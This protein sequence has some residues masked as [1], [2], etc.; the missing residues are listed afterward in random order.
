[1]EMSRAI[2]KKLGAIEADAR[3]AGAATPHR[4]HRRPPEPPA[5]QRQPDPDRVADRRVPRPRMNLYQRHGGRVRMCTGADFNG[6][7][8]T[9]VAVRS[10]AARGQL[11]DAGRLGHAPVRAARRRPRWPS[12]GRPPTS[13]SPPAAPATG[14][15]STSLAR[16]TQGSVPATFE[17]HGAPRSPR[18][19][20]DI[21]PAD[22]RHAVSQDEPHAFAPKERAMDRGR[23]LPAWRFP[24]ASVS[25]VELDLA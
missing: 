8:W 9:V 17:V 11:P 20:F 15:F 24:P 23:P 4:D 1:M 13:T 7:R 22:L 6:M 16:D 3:R 14:F 5:A 18:P 21:A 10:G 19:G 25:V 2:G 12:A